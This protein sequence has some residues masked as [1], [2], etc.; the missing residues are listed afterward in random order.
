M[1]KRGQAGQ[2]IPRFPEHIWEQNPFCNH[3]HRHANRDLSSWKPKCPT[4]SVLL[5]AFVC[6]AFS[7]LSGQVPAS[8]ESSPRAPVISRA[9]NRQWEV[10]GLDCTNWEEPEGSWS[11]K[12][13]P[14]GLKGIHSLDRVDSPLKKLRS[15]SLYTRA[16]IDVFHT[17][18]C[19]F[20]FACLFLSLRLG[21]G[22]GVSV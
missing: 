4:T 21:K 9:L 14:K 6:S 8:D 19:T 1:T 20:R 17:Y 3:Y 13:K 5:H 18:T 22:V 7:L 12:V 10:W 2:V 15:Y 11:M 16:R